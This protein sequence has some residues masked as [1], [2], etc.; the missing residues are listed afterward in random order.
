MDIEHKYVRFYWRKNKKY[1]LILIAIMA[2]FMVLPLLTDKVL[3]QSLNMNFE[4]FDMKNKFLVFVCILMFLVPFYNFSFLMKRESSDFYFSLGIKR[5][6][7]FYLQ[8]ITGAAVVVIPTFVMY[9]LSVICMTFIF[10]VDL[11]LINII[12]I[13]IGIECIALA[14]YSFMV[15]LIILCNHVFDAVL[16]CMSYLV[17]PFFMKFC[18]GIM[19]TNYLHTFILS[20]TYSGSEFTLS[21]DLLAFLSV[22][23]GMLRYTA[24]LN[25]E[26]MNPEFLNK[27]VVPVWPLLLFYIT[28]G[29]VCFLCARAFFQKRRSED[30]QQQTKH[31]LTY[32]LVIVLIT[33]SLLLTVNLGAN[34]YSVLIVIF[35]LFLLLNFIAYHEIA[36][37]RAMLYQFLIIMLV[38]LGITFLF[39]QTQG[40]GYINEIP[41]REKISSVSLTMQFDSTREYQFSSPVFPTPKVIETDY[42]ST[43]GIVREGIDEVLD[44]HQEVLMNYERED[45]DTY[46]YI[47]DIQ[48]RYVLWSGEVITR[49]YTIQ[50]AQDQA[51]CDALINTLIKLGYL[52]SLV[53]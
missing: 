23:V 42:I 53:L 9:M 29:I 41:S 20:S 22:P 51:S 1:I 8:Y 35:S 30:S 47:R 39:Q 46:V 44:F 32:P 19:T 33:F 12:A 34:E 6:T 45:G 48:M 18:L 26:L 15:M 24:A 25:P 31:Y 14:F 7:L 4:Y 11:R 49:N 5:K 36:I 43:N 28:A 38:G 10:Y 27:A 16:V 40:F 13:G 50:T 37:R 2:I 17:V 52:D 21:S 3:P